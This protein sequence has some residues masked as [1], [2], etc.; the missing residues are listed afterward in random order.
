MGTEIRTFTTLKDITEFLLDQEAQYK[1][2]FEDYSQWLGS[3]LR[4]CE[5]AHKNE[6]WY[7]KSAALQKNLKGQPKKAP[8][9]KANGKKNGGKGKNNESSVWIQSGNILLSSTEQGQVEIMF[10]AIEKINDKILELEK[11]K[12]AVQQLERIGLGKTVN[13]VVY[14]E[15]DIPKKIVIRAKNA[16]SEDVFKFATE[17]SVPAVFSGLTIG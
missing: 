9:Q 8:E 13:Y 14:I 10:E 17:F 16:S 12:V 6:D 1:G 7:Q 2:L 15:D 5:D 4:S 3:L 11:F